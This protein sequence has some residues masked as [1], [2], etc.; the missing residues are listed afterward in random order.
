MTSEPEPEAAAEGRRRAPFGVTDWAI[1]SL[2]ARVRIPVFL[3]EAT[4][5]LLLLALIPRSVVQ[6]PDVGTAVVLC[7]AGLLHTEIAVGVERIRRRVTEAL[8]VDLTSVWTFAGALLLPPALAAAV[9]VLVSS[10]LW[11]RSWRPRV[12]LYKQVFN[13]AT[14]VLA[15]LAAGAVTAALGDREAGFG[16]LADLLAVAAALLVYTT[17]NSCLVAGAIAVSVP[18]RGHDR[19]EHDQPDLARLFGD[20]AENA[21]E[22]ATLSLG[23]L[24]ATALS[25]NPYLVAFV[26][27]PLLVLHR[28]VLVRHL[29]RA[30][31]TDYKTGLLNAAAWHAQAE[32]ELS[33][34]SRSEGPRGVLVLDLDHFKSVNDSHGHM[35]G[36][37]V[38]AAVAEEVR[39]EI[40]ERDLAGRFGGEEFVVLL[41]GG[42][43]TAGRDLAA[44]AE[45]IRRRIERLEVLIPTP[46]GPLTV[47]GLTVS[48][49]GAVS[50]A[51]AGDLQSLL[52][53]ADS[54]LYAAKRAGRN[55]VH[56]GVPVPAQAPPVPSAAPP[57]SPPPAPT[58]L[59]PPSPPSVAK[60]VGPGRAAASAPRPAEPPT[61]AR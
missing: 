3:V 22:I 13:T 32:R 33:R 29:E 11:W 48:V 40:R 57:A 8:H 10:H 21:L 17:V 1:W 15:C 30:A 24:A 51:E 9:A 54:A 61:A 28:A 49:G 25:I 45:R 42:D 41:T 50:S 31:S 39:S 7:V 35:A 59:A 4:A 56:M 60:T 20:R 18:Q 12:P 58:P 44:V 2:P 23:A 53:I 55:A 38:L 36:D 26:L 46:D 34:T 27:P 52:Q 14:V 19:R 16:S 47:A 43:R 6:G 37:Q 5:L